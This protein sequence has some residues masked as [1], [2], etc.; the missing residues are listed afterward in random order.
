MCYNNVHPLVLASVVVA[1]TGVRVI[2]SRA[3]IQVVT[4]ELVAL[5][6]VPKANTINCVVIARRS[7]VNSSDV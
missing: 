1:G 6:V 2:S 3:V 7:A 5:R 4:H